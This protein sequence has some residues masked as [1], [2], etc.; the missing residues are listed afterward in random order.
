VRLW[1]E[2][3]RAEPGARPGEGDRVALSADG[4]PIVRHSSSDPEQGMTGEL[5]ALALYAGQ[6]VGLVHEVLPAGEIVRTMAEE[7]ERTLAGLG[8]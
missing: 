4:S 5:E 3:G 2:V 6:S 7:A 8:G 1:E